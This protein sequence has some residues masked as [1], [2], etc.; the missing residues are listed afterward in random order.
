M[1]QKKVMFKDTQNIG[2]GDNKTQKQ[3]EEKYSNEL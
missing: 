2:A 1:H 3:R